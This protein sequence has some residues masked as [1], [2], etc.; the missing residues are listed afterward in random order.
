MNTMFGLTRMN[1]HVPNNIEDLNSLAAFHQRRHSELRRKFQKARRFSRFI[2]GQGTATL[3]LALIAIATPYLEDVAWFFEV[4]FIYMPLVVF[5]A[6]LLL[7]RTFLKGQHESNPQTSNKRSSSK[8]A[9]DK[10][11]QDDPVSLTGYQSNFG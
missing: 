7:I 1:S 10:I 11:Q 6:G 5:V 2:L 8:V 3:C 4:C 9:A